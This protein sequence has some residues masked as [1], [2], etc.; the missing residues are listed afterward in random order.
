MSSQCESEL[1]D[2]V[3][4]LI[5]SGDYDYCDLNTDIQ[6]LQTWFDSESWAG[7]VWTNKI[8]WAPQINQG[9]IIILKSQEILFCIISVFANIYI[10]YYHFTKPVHPKHSL[11]TVSKICIRS[12]I[13]TVIR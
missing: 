2:N 4:K 13:L 3:N 7:A 1:A 8:V 5:Q 10:L 12:H 11:K 6:K 9:P